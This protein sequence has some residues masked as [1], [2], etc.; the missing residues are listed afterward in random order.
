MPE[1]TTILLALKTAA[2]TLLKVVPWA[3]K[4]LPRNSPIAK[5]IKITAEHFSSRLPSLE[6]ALETWVMCDAFRSHVEAIESGALADAEVSHVDLFL[7]TTGYSL[8]LTS[9][10]AVA[11]GLGYFYSELCGQL[12]DGEHGMRLLGAKLDTQHREVMEHLRSGPSPGAESLP[13]RPPVEMDATSRAIT[14]EDRKAEIQLDLIKAL[15]DKRKTSA[16]L[17]LLA[18]LQDSV[19]RGHVSPPVRFRFFVN[20]GVCLMLEGKWDQAEA[21]FQAAQILEPDN[22]KALINLAQV[23][24][25]RDRQEEALAY[26]GRVLAEDP[27]DANANSLRLACLY[28]LG[29]VAEIQVALEAQPALANDSSVLYTLAYI[30]LDQ[31]KFDEAEHY[32]RR[33]NELDASHPEAWEM[34]GRAIVI[35][36]QRQLQQTAASPNWIPDSSRQRIEEAETYLSRAEE[37]LAASESRRELKFTLINRGVARTLL[38]RFDD[39]RQDYEYALRIDPS[40]Q[41]VM[42]NL[43]SLYLHTGRSDEAIRYFEQIT[44][45]TLKLEVAP[46]LAAA[47]LD[48]KKPAAARA[49]LEPLADS[50]DAEERLIVKDLLLVACQ[51]LKDA[52]ACAGLLNSLASHPEDPDAHRIAAEYYAREGNFDQAVKSAQSAVEKAGDGR[53]ARYRLLL[54]D[55]LYRANRFDEAA[56]AYALVPVPTDDS[57]ESRR[58]L[59]A[60][61]NAGRIGKAL[62]VA[63]TVR[64]GGR[65]IPDF[66]EIEALIYERT[67]DVDFANRLRAELLDSGAYAGRQ[68][69]K[70]ALNHYRRDRRDDAARLTL[71]VD[72]GAIEEDSESVR[73]AAMLRTLLGLPDALVFAWR[74]L[75]AEPNDPE[76]HLFYVNTFFRREEVDKPLFHPDTIAVD[77]VVTLRHGT[78]TQ[79]LTIVEG[80]SDTA[81]NLFSIEHRFAEALLGKRTGDRI[82]YPTGEPSEAEYEILGVQSKFVQSFQD[83]MG[84]FNERFPAHYGLTR[85]EVEKDDITKIVV[86]LEHQ[87]ARAERILDLYRSGQLP[88]CAG[89]RLFGKSD[90]EMFRALVEDR[91]IKVLSY[92]GTLDRLQ[93]EASALAKANSVLLESSALV[94][95]QSLGIMEKLPVAFESLHVTQLQVDSLTEVIANLF[96]E[97]QTGHLFSDSPGHIQMVSRTSEEAVREKTFYE[98]LLEFMRSHCQVAM[99]TGHED[100]EEFRKPEVQR[101]LG[102]VAISTLSIAAGTGMLIASDDLPL[103]I[104]ALNSHSTSSVGT[105]SLLKHLRSRSLISGSEYHAAIQWLVERGY[106]FVSIDKDDVVWVL[107]K[108][109]WSPT[110]EVATFLQVLS[111]PD[112]NGRDA[113]S[114]G[115]DVLRELWNEPL[116]SATQQLVSDLILRALVTGRDFHQVLRALEALNSRRSAIWTPAMGQIQQ[117]IRSWQ[118]R[119]RRSS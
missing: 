66:S 51:R 92:H 3:W 53:A 39:A 119:G 116:P 67:G 42:R 76:V 12:L 106:S 99:P 15:V 74:L 87:R 4:A 58:H 41:E 91:Q 21:E 118:P 103:R 105:L 84:R 14:D 62:Q 28:E 82:R 55:I 112:C 98:Q 6:A 10:E 68:K 114:V 40:L 89:A 20:K 72:L 83:C 79:T 34:L 26:L 9:L 115:L 23:A 45:P 80:N 102:A 2:P 8:G 70:M 81:R 37:L 19:D 30:A 48:H 24:R 56:D 100:R 31:Q 78:E 38:G 22:R 75:E 11:E 44:S 33:H 25:F 16:A 54:G 113:I 93:E 90:V 104:L 7:R 29:K 107:R 59:I 43:G 65:A 61:F 50:M 47:Y 110:P 63:Q 1:P 36:A 94:T 46:L 108:S 52:A 27:N 60:L 111:G 117:V 73:D 49:L 35:P 101:I 17:G 97:K 13:Y 95:L 71:E 5:A 96:P 109:N 85:V 69:L 18:T 32:L 88:A 86:M 77:C 57:P 64:K